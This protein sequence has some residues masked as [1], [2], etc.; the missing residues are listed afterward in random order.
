[1]APVDTQEPAEALE[2]APS[3]D[4]TFFS[5]VH[6]LVLTAFGAMDG[7]AAS[8]AKLSLSPGFRFEFQDN[9]LEVNDKV[10]KGWRDFLTRYGKHYFI[11]EADVRAAMEEGPE[12]WLR[13]R[14]TFAT[15]APDGFVEIDAPAPPL[16]P[17]IDAI[18]DAAMAGDEDR[19]IEI[20]TAEMEGF[21]RPAVIEP[22]NRALDRIEEARQGLAPPIGV[23][24]EPPSEE[25]V[26][27]G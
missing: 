26:E 11:D 18:L 13:G 17:V 2:Q 16:Q 3:G 14:P 10:R 25:E 6:N 5:K 15:P 4:A 19:L 24:G 27:G 20:Q 1:M 23:T 12:A 7:Y 22:I 8:G 21:K 9:R